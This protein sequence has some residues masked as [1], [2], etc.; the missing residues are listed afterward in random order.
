MRRQRVKMSS[1]PR[2][3]ACPMCSDPV[4]LGGGM[5]SE[6]GALGAAASAWKYFLSSH[7]AYQRFSSAEGS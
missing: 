7:S 2:P 4:T 1:M 5:T 3:S 6:N